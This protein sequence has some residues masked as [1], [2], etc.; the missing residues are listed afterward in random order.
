MKIASAASNPGT[1]EIRI[2]SRTPTSERSRS[3][4]SGP[5]IA[6]AL[7]IARSKPYA[8]PYASGTTTSVRSALREGVRRPRESQAAERRIATCQTATA[9]PISALRTAVAV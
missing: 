7:S 6:P 9:A 3:A 5:A 8:R 2:A 1:T 4:S